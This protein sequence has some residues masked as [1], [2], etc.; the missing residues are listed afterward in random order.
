MKPL[1]I[2]ID[3][4]SIGNRKGGNETYYLELIRAL[5][6]APGGHHYV[7]YYTS[8]EALA[9]ISAK[10]CVSLVHLQPAHRALRIP[11]IFPWRARQDRLD[12]F[13]AQFI[14]PPFLTCKTVTTIPDIA[15]E[16]FP[17][18]FDVHERISFKVLIPWSAQRAD[19]IITVSEFS[20]QDL[21]RT[22]GIREEKISV[23]HEAAGCAF[24]PV[25]RRE[26][27]QILAVKYG[28]TDDF[29]LYVG[30][31]QA[32]KNL[33]RLVAA[34]AQVRRAGFQHKLVLVGRPDSLFQ[35]VLARIQE[36]HLGTDVI[37]P[38]YIPYKDLASF[39]SAAEVFVYPSFFEGFGLPVMEAMACG[40]PVV[41]SKGS[42][43]EEVAGNAALIIDP[44]DEQSIVDALKRILHEPA[45]ARYLAQEGLRRSRQFSFRN[46]AQQTIE[47]YERLMG[48][49]GD[50]YHSGGLCHR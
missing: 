40:A 20:K 34:Y 2:G 43:L 17:Q 3:V 7:L 33:G 24:R 12:I 38:G 50:G 6:E 47:I 35:P 25:D 30:R 16:H 29:I 10:D 45:L 14:V 26:A 32:R 1:R 31:L 49:G 37:R 44:L 28:I 42:S 41:T 22:Y 23:T 15:Y 9:K 13:H 27:K 4:H 46:T 8:E 39:Y 21:V 48:G 11:F 18:F 19:H 36:L 5:M